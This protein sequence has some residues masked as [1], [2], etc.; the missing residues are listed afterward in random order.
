MRRALWPGLLLALTAARAAGQEPAAMNV[1]AP[2]LRGIEAWLNAEP[3]TLA[4]LK[5][6]VVVL[7]FWTFG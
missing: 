2:E 1:P 7:H 6:R 4:A 3:T 5:G